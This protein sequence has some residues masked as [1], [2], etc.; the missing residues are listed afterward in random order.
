MRRSKLTWAKG[1]QGDQVRPRS[2]TKRTT[3][4]P[5]GECGGPQW[6]VAFRRSAELGTWSPMSSSSSRGRNRR[7]R[8]R[9]PP[10][11]TAATAA[12]PPPPPPPAPPRRRSTRHAVERSGVA[13]VHHRGSDVDDH[14]DRA[15]CERERGQRRDGR[16]DRRRVRQFTHSA[17]Y[18][19]ECERG[20]DG[21]SARRRRR[22]RPLGNDQ[23]R[24]DQNADSDRDRAAPPPAPP[25]PPPP[26]HRHRRRHHR[27]AAAPPPVANFTFRC[28]AL[29][30][31]STRAARRAGHASY[32]WNWVTARRGAGRPRRTRMGAAGAAA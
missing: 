32:G 12:A 28:T 10:A 1:R 23:W 18:P 13:N 24:G 3:S 5:P 15:G 14:G 20:H 30:C 6:T 2:R 16:P 27:P 26:R 25:P 8:R 31:N 9:P 11:T 7:R 19:D 22:P 4:C 29:T 17:S 21:R